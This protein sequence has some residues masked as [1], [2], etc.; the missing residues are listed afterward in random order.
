MPA[1]PLIECI[2]EPTQ[3][4]VRDVWFAWFRQLALM[5]AEPP[6]YGDAIQ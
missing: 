1:A 4:V 3:E 2:C 6:F 5:L